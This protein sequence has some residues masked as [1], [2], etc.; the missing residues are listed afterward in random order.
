M[1]ASGRALLVFLSML[2]LPA[3]ANDVIR[4]APTIALREGYAGYPEF[5]KQCDWTAEFPARLAEYAKGMV[6]LTDQDLATL[7][8]RTL[9]VRIM[10][11]RAADGGGFSG[12]KWAAIRAEL[13]QDGTLIGQY[14]P[15]SR[16]MTPF[17][18][19]CSSLSKLS[20]ALAGD[21]AAWLR[22][23]DF[24]IEFADEQAV[25]EIGPEEHVPP[26]Q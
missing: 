10:N 9:R 3:V 13:Y 18:D 16:T 23:G 17:R 11:M 21:T 12:P 14:Q 1:N 4:T 22:R 20:D 7:P 6:E 15:F 8:G 19:G 24:K 26:L 25:I 2:A 5:M